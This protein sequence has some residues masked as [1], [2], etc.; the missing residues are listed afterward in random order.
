MN[1]AE[2]CLLQILLFSCV[3][4][5]KWWLYITIGLIINYLAAKAIAKYFDI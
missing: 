2:H 1:Y 3:A 4:I 5:R